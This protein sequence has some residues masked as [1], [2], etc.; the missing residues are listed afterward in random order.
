M[1]YYSAVKKN[2][3]LLLLSL[4]T[5]NNPIYSNMDRPRVYHTKQSK[6]EKGKHHTVSLVCGISN[7]VQISRK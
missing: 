1:E 3:L 2:E 4:I 7:T 6:P 5:V